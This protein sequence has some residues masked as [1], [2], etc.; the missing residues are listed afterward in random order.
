[1]KENFKTP[2][3]NNEG[4]DILLGGLHDFDWQETNLPLIGGGNHDMWEQAENN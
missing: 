2:A 1:M 4:R 3:Q